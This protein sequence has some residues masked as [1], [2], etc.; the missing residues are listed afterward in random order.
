MMK[1]ITPCLWFN[2]NAQEAMDFYK[3]VFKD[4]RVTDTQRYP[5]LPAEDLHGGK[6]GAVVTIMFEINGQPF[7]AL[8]GGSI[9]P[10]TEAFS[11]M[12]P[13]KDQ[14]EIDYYFTKL[15]A[16]PESEQCGWVK[17]KFGISW[18]IVPA[19]WTEI[20][21]GPNREAY[22][23]AMMQMKKLDIAKLKAAANSPKK[24]A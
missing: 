21:S 10:P 20:M 12:V 22:F 6:P 7:M 14:A 4:F 1:Q 18:Q 8:N 3:S 17:D 24:A 19:E 23:S 15:S 13:C 9:F 11:L 2:N 16:V 5:D